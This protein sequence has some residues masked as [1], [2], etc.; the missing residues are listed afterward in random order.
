[1][2]RCVR[3]GW[4]APGGVLLGWA[5]S[6][7]TSFPIWIGRLTIPFITAWLGWWL[8]QW[9]P[10]LFFPNH[11]LGIYTEPLGSNLDRTV[12][13][14]TQNFTVVAWW[15]GAVLVA[16]IQRD[17]VSAMMCAFI[18]AGFGPGF[19]L[20]AIW[21]LGFEYAPTYIDWWKMWEL[22]SGFNLGIL[23]VLAWYWCVRQVDKTH[24]VN[25]VS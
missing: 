10:S 20:A 19:A 6:Q 11:N 8:V 1:M 22:Q 15:I 17:K 23:Y 4:G 13:T 7:K 14:N 18:G 9:Y 24:N 3:V 16:T 21:C 25:V 5:L 12:Y 2:V